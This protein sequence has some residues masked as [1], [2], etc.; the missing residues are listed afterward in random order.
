[1]SGYGSQ[2]IGSQSFLCMYYIYICI[3]TCGMLLCGKCFVELLGVRKKFEDEK[4]GCNAMI[5]FA[6]TGIQIIEGS[7]SFVAKDARKIVK[8]THNAEI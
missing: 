8:V 1:M 5:T 6:S 2:R 7:E 3:H 4:F